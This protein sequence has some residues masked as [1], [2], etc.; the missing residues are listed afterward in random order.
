[1]SRSSSSL[2]AYLPEI[3]S[4]ETVVATFSDGTI[5]GFGIP[6]SNTKKRILFLL[7]SAFIIC[8]ETLTTYTNGDTL[9]VL[10]FVSLVILSLALSGIGRGRTFFEVTYVF[11]FFI[12]IFFHLGEKFTIPALGLYLVCGLWIM[13]GYIFP[14]IISLIFIEILRP[15][16]SDSPTHNYLSSL[17]FVSLTVTAALLMRSLRRERVTLR[18]Q[19]Q[20]LEMKR[21]QEQVR[22]RQDIARNIHDTVARD[23]SQIAV[24]S[25]AG[26]ANETAANSFLAEI[27]AIAR[28]TSRKVRPMVMAL[29]SSPASSNFPDLMAEV[30]NVLDPKCISVE[31]EG[32]FPDALPLSSSA[33]LAVWSFLRETCANVL[34]YAPARSSVTFTFEASAGTLNVSS[35]NS[36]DTSPSNSGLST[37]YGLA[38][39]SALFEGADGSF[40]FSM[41]GSRWVQ[42]ATVPLKENGGTVSA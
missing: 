30:R 28:N 5:T 9:S 25:S 2:S 33:R 40:S 24:L 6:F 16:F 34:K 27:S 29:G 41:L 8:W 11:I 17:L 22:L 20:Q 36:V 21:R 19:L 26:I 42:C 15:L 3:D 37:G 18:K 4:S 23:L 32:T 14:G 35:T 10:D 39:L 38:N 1:M 12:T 7:L 31:C 13:R